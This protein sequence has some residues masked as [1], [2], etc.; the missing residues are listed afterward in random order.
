PAAPS[1]GPRLTRAPGCASIR[2]TGPETGESTA[3]EW[4]PLNATVPIVTTDA[5]KGTARAVSVLIW[6]RWALSSTIGSVAAPA[7]AGFVLSE[8]AA[9]PE[10][11]PAAGLPE[12]A[13]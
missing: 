10:A 11:V 13:A 9:S 2:E 8:A 5:V 1:A 4:S 12:Q 7:A 3:V 6:A